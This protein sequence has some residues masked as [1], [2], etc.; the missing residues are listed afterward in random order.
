M[1]F[2]DFYSK[3]TR[4]RL[5]IAF[6]DLT[7]FT[8]YCLAHPDE[9]VFN[10]IREYFLLHGQIVEEAGG[11]VIKHMGDAALIAF[12]QEKAEAGILALKKLR[13]ESD[14]W[15]REHGMRSRLQVKVHFGEAIVGEVGTPG[16][17]RKDIYGESVNLAATLPG[18]G[19]SMS[20]QAFRT[21]GPDART[22]FKKH[23]P[24]ITYIAREDSH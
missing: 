18:S 14:L 2:L 7:L 9:E 20:P 24:P 23:T 22:L 8:R 3:P 21:L 10:T 5:L 12:P 17:K 1:S 19:F 16:W 11:V 13:D 15:L 6:T 4:A